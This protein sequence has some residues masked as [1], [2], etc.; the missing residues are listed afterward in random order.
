MRMMVV[1]NRGPLPLLVL[2]S[3]L[4][5]L[6]CVEG[7]DYGRYGEWAEALLRGSAASISSDTVSPSGM[8]VSHWAH[9]TGVVL[10][11]LHLLYPSFFSPWLSA[12]CVGVALFLISSLSLWGVLDA[13]ELEHRL[14]LL[15]Y[16]L[17]LAG[18]NFG[19][20]F[21][22]L[23]SQVVT[24]TVIMSL[25]WL[26]LTKKRNNFFSA[27][28]VSVGSCIL[29]T[30]RPQAV[31][32]LIPILG[33]FAWRE[34][35][36]RNL[37]QCALFLG[38]VGIGFSV[39]LLQV[40]QV[41]QWMTGSW[42]HSPL[43][44]GDETFQSLG[45][46]S[47]AVAVKILLSY[48]HGVG[49]LI[50]TPLLGLAFFAS[51]GLSFRKSLAAEWRLF[52]GLSCIVNVANLA[53][54]SGWFGWSG[55]ESFGARYFIPSA[56]LLFLALPVTLKE[57]GER[58]TAVSVLVL[59]LFAIPTIV[60][61][62]GLTVLDL[63]GARRVFVAGLIALI[64]G[65]MALGTWAVVGVHQRV[66]LSRRMLAVAAST[67]ILSEFSVF[68]V[69]KSQR[70]KLLELAPVQQWGV[71]LVLVFFV[72]LIVLSVNTYVNN[73]DE[74]AGLKYV[75]APGAI[76]A[77][78][79]ALT[80]FQAIKFVE[81]RSATEEYRRAQIASP[82]ARFKFKLPFNFEDFSESVDE[83]QQAHDWSD[84]EMTRLRT[85]RDKIRATAALQRF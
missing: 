22:H 10:S 23:S 26:V 48:R 32:A 71:A 13:I 1:E 28:A 65:L 19:Y 31:L 40:V 64:V 20:Y 27:I 75:R 85:F 25:C 4:I 6:C 30:S 42:F 52:F 51:L 54:I 62:H 2:L 29:I 45:L 61:L 5:F 69:V 36:K 59:S 21:I 12:R 80:L 33:V 78:G 77:V 47:F 68:A 79:L 49:I 74:H 8:P 34:L 11:I 38:V 58:S 55:E 43:S 72:V 82:D 53:I 17:F 63:N 16:S 9:G 44:F 41:N 3:A 84:D 7:P 66:S 39:G 73:E 46:P 24:S 37:S 60:A 35:Q 81:F 70:V 18:T 57:A 67:V 83:G 50:F 14:K 76:A 15:V 56:L